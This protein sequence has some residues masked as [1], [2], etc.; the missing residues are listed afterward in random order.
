MATVSPAMISAQPNTPTAMTYDEFLSW[1]DGIHAEWIK[2][3]VITF[4]SVTTAHQRIVIFL[5]FLLQTFAQYFQKGEVL[6]APVQI[7]LRDSGR[8]PDIFLVAKENAGRVQEKFF[9]GAPDLIVE[10]ISDESASR[11]R[12]D[13]FEEY[14]ESGVREYWLIDPRP[15]RQRADFYQLGKDGKYRP[16]PIDDDGVYR[17]HVLQGFW[18]NV[19]WLWQ[20]PLPDLL[21]TFEMIRGKS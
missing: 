10:V 20:D 9:D 15:K 8:E 6:T 11:D 13:K 2:G 21:P 19:N 12:V 14:E 4:M 5:S 17:S 16:V 18:L 1:S 7:K 3:E